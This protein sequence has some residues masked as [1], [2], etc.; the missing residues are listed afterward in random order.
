MIH[1]KMSHR[2][3]MQALIAH[4]TVDRI[5][6]ALWRHFP[7]DDQDAELLAAATVN[8]QSQYDFDVVKVTPASSFCLKD[9]GAEDRWEGNP[10]GTRR[11][12]KHVI[13][14]PGDW[15]KLPLI[16]PNVKYLSQQLECLNLLKKNIDKDTP[17]IQTVFSPLSQAKN[18]AGG[19][20]LLAHLRAFPEA[21]Q[22]GLEI[23]TQST[24]LF[25]QAV[26]EIGADGIFYAIQH[27]QA[28]LLN[29][30]EYVK[31]GK[32]Q[33]EQILQQARTLWCNI[34]HLHGTKVYFDL[35]KGFPVQIINWHD[36]ETSPS[37]EEAFHL[38]QGVLC[39]GL[40][41]ETL[42]LG[43]P[44]EINCEIKDAINQVGGKRL[45]LGTGCVIPII[46]PHG[47]IK[48][49]RSAVEP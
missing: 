47:N 34:L 33:D 27:A 25:V 17:L 23:I 44:G 18:L 20:V 12:T 8:F 46:S 7:V 16:K 48:F 19:E 37:L 21:V 38:F 29:Q 22:K 13:Q 14:S 40:K 36:R 35:I 31:F 6:V 4:K 43:T 41:R 26:I 39:G 28:D 2:D 5:P 49:V 30:T 32:N 10:E 15:E 3:R 1:S 42:S 24:M 45:L 9:W 11:Y